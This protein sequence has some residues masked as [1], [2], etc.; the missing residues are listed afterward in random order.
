MIEGLVYR[1]NWLSETESAT[2]LKAVD[3]TAWMEDLQRRV[4]HFGYRYDYKARKIVAEAYLGPLPKWSMPMVERM[5]AEGI[6]G[7]MP[8]QL[9][10][11]EYLPGQGISKHVDCVPCFTDTI[12]S[13]TLGSSAVMQLRNP[14]TAEMRPILLMPGSLLKLSGEARYEWQ[15]EIPGRQT[16]TWQ[17]RKIPRSR[18]VSLTF[19]KV[20]L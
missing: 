13:I 19:R 2:Y 16:D 12:V 11:N 3:E 15:H 4:Q 7:E 1:E 20:I 9:I 10:V 17:G 8:D 6:F 14:Q 18:R 5:M